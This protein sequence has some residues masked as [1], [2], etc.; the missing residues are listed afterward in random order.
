MDQPRSRRGRRVLTALGALGAIVA[1]GAALRLGAEP[2][3]PAGAQTAQL[4]GDVHGMV[5]HRDP[6]TGQ[7]G[8]PPSNFVIG[9]PG[10]PQGPL[11]ER[12][13]RTRGGGFAVDLHGRG[14]KTMMATRDAAGNVVVGCVDGAT[15]A[16]E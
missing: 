3:R 9:T 13:G 12:R 6:L 5:I 4:P 8:A 11:P 16:R 1:A 14:T 2:A 15:G 10:A 7:L